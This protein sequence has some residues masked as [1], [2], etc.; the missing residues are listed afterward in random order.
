VMGNGNRRE[1]REA[2]AG[3]S[4]NDERGGVSL[5]RSPRGCYRHLFRIRRRRDQRKSREADHALSGVHQEQDRL[6]ERTLAVAKLPKKRA[7]PT[8]RRARC[9]RRK[10][11][12]RK[13]RLYGGLPQSGTK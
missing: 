2:C 1:C 11:T 13:R 4:N 12:F 7:S 10:S 6:E 5:S 9:N 3:S 8:T